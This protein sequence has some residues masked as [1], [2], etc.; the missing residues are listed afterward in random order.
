MDC[1]TGIEVTYVNG[2]VASNRLTTVE[3]AIRGLIGRRG[4]LPASTLAWPY[5]SIIS[6]GM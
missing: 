1:Q 6:E 4:A 5:A 2:P 3:E